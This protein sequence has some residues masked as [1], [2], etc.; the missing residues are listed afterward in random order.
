M[1]LG[2]SRHV[3][4]L[5]QELRQQGHK[6]ICLFGENLRARTYL[7]FRKPDALNLAACTL[8]SIMETQAREGCDLVNV[9]GFEGALYG[10]ARRRR[11]G[12]LPPLVVT[13]FG[14]EE[15]W[16]PILLQEARLG[17]VP[18]VSWRQKHITTPPWLWSVR[19]TLKNSDHVVCVSSEE[20]QSTVDRY[21]RKESDVSFIFT[22]VDPSFFTTRPEINELGPVRL[23]F[24]GT[25]HWRKGPVYLREAYL[26][27]LSKYPGTQLSLVGT[28]AEA[29]E[30]MAFFPPSCR[31]L[32]RV[33][34]RLDPSEM[35]REY[36]NHDI[37]VLPS[38]FEGMPLSIA[39]AMAAGLPVVSTQ[40]CGM[41]DLVEEGKTGFLVPPRDI[42]SLAHKIGVLIANPSLQR[43][44]G[45]Q[46]QKRA[47][48][49]GW[50]RV[51]QEFAKRYAQLL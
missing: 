10:L 20:C 34:P 14:N 41:I 32:L 33:Q 21:Q 22:G 3:H 4:Y 26:R 11:L 37:F 35:P 27:L 39:E 30:V 28:F 15:R 2:V 6:V 9:H 13:T 23:L 1:Q 38:L 51:A 44:L 5:A 29:T 45:Q 47:R 46:G 24:V 31:G 49:L 7:P 8:A 50:D 48:K 19:S 42:D 16:W 40:T 12:S 43:A 18:R 25:W 17:H 36:A